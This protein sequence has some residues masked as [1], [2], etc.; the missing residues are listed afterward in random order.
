V[1]ASEWRGSGRLQVPRST[2]PRRPHPRF[3]SGQRQ[4]GA[5]AR[6]RGSGAAVRAGAARRRR[7]KAPPLGTARPHGAAAG[8]T[9]S[10]GSG[11]APALPLPA[12]PPL[13]VPGDRGAWVQHEGKG[14]RPRA[15]GEGARG[16]CRAPGGEAGRAGALRPDQPPAEEHGG[17]L[18]YWV[19]WFPLLRRPARVRRVEGVTGVRPPMAAGGWDAGVLVLG[20]RRGH[21]GAEGPDDFAVFQ[22]LHPDLCREALECRLIV[23]VAGAAEDG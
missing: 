9:R 11:Q 7:V 20:G 5:P 15:G 2:L 19:A 6:R 14:A 17:R 3:V 18:G 1:S 23:E 21:P 12:L 22:D 4:A 13:A 10:A 16:F 8:E